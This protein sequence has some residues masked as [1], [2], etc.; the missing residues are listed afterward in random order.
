MTGS[1]NSINNIKEQIESLYNLNA[2]ISAVYLTG[3]KIPTIDTMTTINARLG[4]IIK[5]LREEIDK[6]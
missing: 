3:Q 1:D 2:Q 4:K 5:R 6:L